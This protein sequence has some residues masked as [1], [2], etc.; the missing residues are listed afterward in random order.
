MSILTA[1]QKA[2]AQLAAAIHTINEDH[3]TPYSVGTWDKVSY[4]LELLEDLEENVRQEELN[5]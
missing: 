2:E 1:L 4:L 3:S 5:A